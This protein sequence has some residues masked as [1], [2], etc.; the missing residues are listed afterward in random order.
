MTDRLLSPLEAAE[1]L[2]VA[3][4]TLN[5]WRM[6]GKGPAYVKMGRMVRYSESDLR[7]WVDAH[8]K[9]GAIANG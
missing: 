1:Y 7:S 3:R 4:Q 8:T 9:G 2:G 5:C 6:A